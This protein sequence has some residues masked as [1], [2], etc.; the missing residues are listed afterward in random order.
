MG[1]PG[2]PRL[3]LLLAIQLPILAIPA[4]M[5]ISNYPLPSPSQVG[6]GLRDRI[7]DWRV[8]Q[9]LVWFSIVNFGNFGD[10]G[11]L[12]FCAPLPILSAD[13]PTRGRDIFVA[14]KGSTLIRQGSHK[15]VEGYLLTCCALVFS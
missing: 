10:F 13:A 6:V 12:L 11:N 15:T 3:V 1:R 9:G 2:V 14:N 7:P 5:A 4:I 8:V